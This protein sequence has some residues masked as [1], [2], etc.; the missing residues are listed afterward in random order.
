[1]LTFVDMKKT[2]LG[3]AFICFFDSFKD[4]TGLLFSDQFYVET[5]YY[6]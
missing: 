6:L 2:P 3:G 1:M 4:L 5:G